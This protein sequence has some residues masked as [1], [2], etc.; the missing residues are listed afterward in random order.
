MV[1]TIGKIVLIFIFKLPFFWQVG[2]WNT[3]GLHMFENEKPIWPSNSSDIPLDIPNILKGKTLRIA[4]ILVSSLSKSARTG[5]KIV[6]ISINLTQYFLFGVREFWS[7]FDILFPFVV[8]YIKI[9]PNHVSLKICP[10]TKEID[11]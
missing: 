1:I 10:H 2:E 4:T 9:M 6:Q 11:S 8:L 5:C 3:T 7:I